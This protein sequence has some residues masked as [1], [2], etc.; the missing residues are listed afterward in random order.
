MEAT[1]PISNIIN[2]MSLQVE[3]ILVVRISSIHQGEEWIAVQEPGA[4]RTPGVRVVRCLSTRVGMGEADAEAQGEGQ[5][6]PKTLSG[7]I[8]MG[9]AAPVA[10]LRRLR[11]RPLVMGRTI[12]ALTSTPPTHQAYRMLATT[13]PNSNS[14]RA[15]RRATRR[16]TPFTPTEGG[17]GEVVCVHLYMYTC[18]DLLHVCVRV[19][20]CVCMYVYFS[21]CEIKNVTHNIIFGK[22]L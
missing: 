19:S 2:N 18:L 4:G 17:C 14:S 16:P 15:T 12:I 1:G 22:E 8:Q 7:H 3:V 21:K 11:L 5:D 13:L 9:P 20:V 10:L 6:I